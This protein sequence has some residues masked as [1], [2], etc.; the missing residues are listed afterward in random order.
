MF[1][2]TTQRNRR[3]IA[4]I[5]GWLYLAIIVSS[6]LSLIF[7]GGKYTVMG[8]TAASVQKMLQYETYVRINAV[9]EAFM[10]SAVIVLAVLLFELTKHVNAALARSAMLLRVGE[11]FLGFLGIVLSLGVL[12]VTSSNTGLESTESLA[13]L[14]YDLKDSV[15]KILMICISFGTILFFSLFHKARYIPQFLALWGIVGFI[16]MFIASCMQILTITGGTVVNGVAAV[17]AIS[18]ECVIGFWFIKN[19]ITV[20]TDHSVKDKT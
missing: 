4:R 7:L 6:I 18:F 10:F 12:A 19:G 3:E 1:P 2:E 15:Y 13:R 8:D 16:L 5:A 20:K 14:L 11:A 17:L 9:Y